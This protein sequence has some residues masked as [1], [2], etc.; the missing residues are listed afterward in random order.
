MYY[1]P[2]FLGQA[3][4]HTGLLGLS[5]HHARIVHFYDL[6]FGVKNENSDA[7]SDLPTAFFVL[8]FGF[9]FALIATPR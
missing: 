6:L 3:F 5:K 1:I 8:R 2:N 9:R 4:W 7:N